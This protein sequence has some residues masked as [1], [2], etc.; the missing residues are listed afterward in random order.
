MAHRRPQQ[1]TLSI[2]V[3]A[4]LRQF[5]ERARLVISNGRGEGVSTSDVAKLLLE[6]AVDDGLD[7]RIEVAHLQCDATESLSAIRQKWDLDRGLTHAA[8]LLLARFVQFGCE[9]AS[10]NPELPGAE[11][12]AQLLQAVLAVRSLRTDRGVELDRYYLGNL[13]WEGI[14]ERRLDPERVPET[15]EKLTRQLRQSDTLGN[16]PISAG[17]NL[18]VAIRDERLPGVVAL[19]AALNSSRHRWPRDSH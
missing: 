17:R 6:S 9:E 1:Q 5:L 13:G 7:H 18:Y 8:W 19:N 15:T 3:S 10:P 16:R 14:N 4:T 12:L 11:S 2:R